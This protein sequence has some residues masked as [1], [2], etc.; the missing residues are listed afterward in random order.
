MVTCLLVDNELKKCY[1]TEKFLTY[2]FPLCPLFSSISVFIGNDDHDESWDAAL[3]C[4][5][6]CRVDKLRLSEATL[7]AVRCVEEHPLM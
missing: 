3:A 4:T 5:T 6:L 2:N 7:N 1:E